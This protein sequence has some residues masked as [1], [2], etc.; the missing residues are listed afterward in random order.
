M[1]G[2]YDLIIS[3]RIQ[4][5]KPP[6]SDAERRLLYE[7]LDMDGIRDPLVVWKG[8]HILVDGYYRYIYCCERGVSFDL[9]EMDFPDETEAML[10]VARNQLARRN[11]TPFQKCEMVL[12]LEAGIAAEAKKRQGWRSEINGRVTAEPIN[13]VK[14]LAN[15]A[16]VS[17]NSLYHVK[18]II[19]NGDQETIRRARS[20]ELSI[21]GA[22]RSLIQRLEP[23]NEIV[24]TSVI[25]ETVKLNLEP[26][27]AA[28]EELIDQVRGGEASP[29]TI[30]AEL[31]RVAKMIDGANG[32]G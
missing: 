24:K 20:G 11:L 21:Y 3:E 9:I 13:T 29:R 32:A 25:N 12:P 18:Y 31:S 5:M 15:M 19:Q 22:Y 28:V 6:L 17:K 16:G 8:T 7:A 14:I 1:K 26:I 2:H 4:R 30:V 27:R 10:W 23:S